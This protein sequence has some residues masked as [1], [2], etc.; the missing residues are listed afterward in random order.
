MNIAIDTSP[1]HTEHGRRGVGTYA[2]NLIASLKQYASEHS[3]TLFTRK[4]NIPINADIVHYPYFDPFFL[5]LPIIKPKPTVVTVHDLTPLVFPGK[6]PAGL[7]GGVK[8]QI[9]KQSLLGAKRIL[10]DSEYSKRDIERI[11]GI[12]PSRIDAIHLAPDPQFIRV[13]DVKLLTAVK[14]KFEL[15]D[16]FVLYVGD[17]NWNKNVQ[18]LLKAFA[19]LAPKAKL[20]LVGAAF[21]NPG[22][23]E[24][25]DIQ[26]VIQSLNVAQ[27]VILT[28]F[29]SGR[30]LSALYSLATCLVLPSFY[31]GFG[32][33]MLEAMACG[34]PV[35][36]ATT[37]SLREIAGP[38]IGVQPERIESIAEGMSHIFTLTPSEREKLVG[39]GDAWVRRFTWKKTARQ[40]V[41]S[42]ERAM[43]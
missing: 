41:A 21:T 9:Q 25:K 29:V 8:W 40:T 3:Y 19:Q 1:L 23:A 33:P 34:C 26:R 2:K 16:R 13:T 24:T 30:E 15:P 27:S 4:Q 28:G 10:T 18:G 43:Q 31:E 32:F 35:V 39:E 42:Y 20:V 37:S 6:F 7:R 11:I 36:T 14:K 22:L 5:T 38:A 17:V 12:S